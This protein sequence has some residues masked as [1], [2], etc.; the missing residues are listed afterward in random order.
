MTE[1]KQST[2]REP[3]AAWIRELASI[4]K[5]TDLTEIEMER[6]GLRLRVARAPA[7][8]PVA[9][10]A[11]QAAP[12]QQQQAAP[13][14]APPETPSSVDAADMRSHPGAITSPMVGTVYRAPAPGEKPF[15]EPGDQVSQGQTL[16]I[17]EAMKTM[18][19]ITAPRAGT[20]S[21][22][23]IDDAQPVEFGEALL[24]L[25]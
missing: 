15:V 2:E 22:I 7:V 12:P 10:P 16:L 13:Q 8:A 5:E 24:I 3:E 17:V 20:V 1:K 14:S 4:L 18:N 25:T 21:E 23:L 11:L 19:P 6:E 9:A